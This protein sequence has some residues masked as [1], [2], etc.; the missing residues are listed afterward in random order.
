MGRGSPALKARYGE[1][2]RM[3]LPLEKEERPPL[4]W[5]GNVALFFVFSFLDLRLRHAQDS[6]VIVFWMWIKDERQ[7]SIGVDGSFT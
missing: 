4:T 3:S 7:P 2:Q 6:L 5:A 1:I